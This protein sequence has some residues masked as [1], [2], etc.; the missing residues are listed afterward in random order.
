[1]PM[2]QEWTNLGQ[3]GIQQKRSLYNPGSRAQMPLA[4][5]VQRVVLLGAH[6]HGHQRQINS[7]VMWDRPMM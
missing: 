4:Q 2:R 3:T 1:M 5:Q 6:D 7:T